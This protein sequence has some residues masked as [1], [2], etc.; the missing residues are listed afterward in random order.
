MI[1]WG[2]VANSHDASIA[3]FKD[4]SLKWAGLAKDFSKIPNDPHLNK[5][6]IRRAMRHGKP[7]KVIWYE[8]PFLKTLR[9]YWA[10]QGW[11]GKENNIR[12]Y[13]RQS[14]ILIVR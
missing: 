2:I 4:D 11:L 9:Q 13:L 6:L 5:K 8:R 10:G 14:R 7:N 12:A 1:T 3:V